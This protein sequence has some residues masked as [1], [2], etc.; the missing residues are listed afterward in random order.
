MCLRKSKDR[1]SQPEYC[2]VTG[3]YQACI[4]G[5]HAYVAV[6][7]MPGQ[8]QHR[9]TVRPA[10]GT[11]RRTQGG[12]WSSRVFYTCVPVLETRCCASSSASAL[13]FFQSRAAHVVPLVHPTKSKT[14]V[15]KNK[16]EM[17]RLYAHE[18][19]AY[20]IH[21]TRELCTRTLLPVPACCICRTKKARKLS[22]AEPRREA[23][24]ETVGLAV[25]SYFLQDKHQPVIVGQLFSAGSKVTDGRF[26]P[27][28]ASNP[29]GVSHEGSTV[30]P[31]KTSC[32]RAASATKQ[33][34]S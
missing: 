19:N 27:P 9:H 17:A 10:Q 34:R 12:V 4:W 28:M 15:E 30:W 3:T 31:S 25:R 33:G 14:F 13:R 32:H 22:K 26:R 5:A 16:K 20:Q 23:P 8:E 29:S 6:T 7:A 1:D 2:Q 21:T 11:A 24:I 18:Y